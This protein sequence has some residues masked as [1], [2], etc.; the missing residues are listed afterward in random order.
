MAVYSK[1]NK[2]KEAKKDKNRKQFVNRKEEEPALRSKTKLLLL[3]TT[4]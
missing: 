1:A 2:L 4:Y 3:L